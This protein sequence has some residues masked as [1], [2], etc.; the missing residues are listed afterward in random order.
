MSDAGRR[1]ADETGSWETVNRD[2]DLAKRLEV[3]PAGR[4]ALAAVQQEDLGQAQQEEH[5]TQ[6]HH[7]LLELH[8]HA[9]LGLTVCVCVCVVIPPP[10][11][12]LT[13]DAWPP[14]LAPRRRTCPPASNEL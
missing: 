5:G 8:L 6:D 11:A 4:R 10:P 12:P 14:Q 2:A 13:P 3:T 1:L 7:A 9:H